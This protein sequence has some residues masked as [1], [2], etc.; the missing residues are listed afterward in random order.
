MEILVS[1]LLAVALA[2]SVFRLLQSRS[3]NTLLSTELTAMRARAAEEDE[4]MAA[5]LSLVG[6]LK[7]DLERVKP[8]LDIA[9]AVAEAAR[10]KS[11]AEAEAVVVKRESQGHARERIDKAET[12]LTEAGAQAKAIVE[13]A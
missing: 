11:S 12:T 9:D 3:N 1:V 2:W 10:I 4:K 7:G 5:A 8:Y 13:M 6:T